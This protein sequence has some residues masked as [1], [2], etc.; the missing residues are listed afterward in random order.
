MDKE[1][2]VKDN[3]SPAPKV[4]RRDGL[5][6]FQ[7]YSAQQ[8]RELQLSIDPE[9]FPQNYRNLLAALDQKAAPVTPQST[10]G[11]FVAGR[12]G[13]R[14]G[15]LGW[16]E[17]K[18]R[19]SPMYGVGSLRVESPTISMIGWQRTWLGVPV[20]AHVARDIT[21]IRNVVQHDSAICFEVTRK[22]LP[23]ERIQFQPQSSDQIGRLVEK[24]PTK[25]TE[26]FLARWMA[27][28]AFDQNL[29]SLGTRVWATSG[30]VALNMLVF[31]AMAI[32]TRKVG[33]FDLQ[34][35]LAW[36]A[37]FGPLTVSAQWWRLFTA[38]FLH[39]SFLHIFLNMW[40][41]WNIGRL[42]ERLFGSGSFLFLY[43]AAGIIASLTS[44][45][46]DPS[47]T[48]VGASGAI[49]GV[50][51]AFLVF[52][53]R[54]RH[55]IPMTIVR[56]LW[57]STAAFVLFN[58]LSGFFQPGI[59][60]AAHVGGLLSGI[61]IGYILSRP[62][63]PVSR[64]RFP[65][66]KVLA[67][68]CVVGA[69][70]FAALWQV[71]GIGSALTV[72]ERFLRG[73]AAYVGGEAINLQ[74]WNE[75]AQRAGA[76]NISDSELAQRFETDI[77]PFWKTQ[78]DVLKRESDALKGPEHG[79][80][81]LVA[82]FAKSRFEWASALIKTVRNGDNSR[83]SEI[84]VLAS[85]TNAI[86]ASLDRLGIRARMEHRPRAL[87]SA[88]LVMKIRQILSG[89]Q[90]TC[91]YGPAWSSPPV[92]NADNKTDGPAMR[93]EAGCNAQR[94]FMAGDFDRLD[95]IMNQSISELE[96]LPDGSSRYEGI[97][98]GLTDLFRFGNVTPEIALGRTADWRREIK[99]STMAE[100]VEAMVFTEWAW[101]ARGN[102]YAN[103]VSNQNMALYAYRTEMA[104]AALDELGERASSNPLWYTLS[105]EVGLDQRKDREK[106]QAIFDKGTSVTSFYRPLY[107]R[108]LRILMPRWGGSYEDV[109]QFI[110]RAYALSAAKR[111]FERYAELYSAYARLEGDDL[112]LFADSKAYW[113]AM[114]TGYLGL[115]KRYPR[116]DFVLNS[117]GNFACR[118]DDRDAYKELRRQIGQRISS[119][120]WSDKYSLESCDKKLSTANK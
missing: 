37:N 105:L 94:L 56:R 11:D 15:L 75:L 97:V 30:I 79:Y 96:D 118:A 41:L 67:A 116:S 74:L 18:L 45:A 110:N 106:V 7:A 104:A 89:H 43:V 24:L 14:S 61:A 107:R 50:F 10:P 17:A 85:K 120:A 9:V 3:E 59:D 83:M 26:G 23:S 108:M 2:P 62:L 44:V 42:S 98:S 21:D 8:L 112:D 60:N 119:T 102:G 109:D 46:W 6:D 4:D 63:D 31:V 40:A 90:T 113:S 49:F 19:R 81:L 53:L 36:G 54:Q 92:S 51:G 66:A 52:L 65:L 115:V 27:V 64:R 82:D 20:E 34:D 68:T 38:L 13:V 86:N 103:T 12:Y 32:A 100:L 16:V 71:K 99:D 101:S 57:I 33:L 84:Q 93:R 29:R 5:I 80:T 72:P 111:G 117:F 95:A 69:V 47:L 58:L 22:Y 114:K 78:K 35:L 28:R 88:P 87:R 77:L 76:G 91:V 55:Q 73:H 1:D 48:S 70:V 39:F 25:T